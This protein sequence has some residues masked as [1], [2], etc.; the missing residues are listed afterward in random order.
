MCL[1]TSTS[2]AVQVFTSFSF[3]LHNIN[4]AYLLAHNV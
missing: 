2:T 1:A 3:E 4:I